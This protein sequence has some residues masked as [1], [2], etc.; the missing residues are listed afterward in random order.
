MADWICS[1]RFWLR[2]DCVICLS[3]PQDFTKQ[4]AEKLEDWVKTLPTVENQTPPPQECAEIG[5]PLPNP[6]QVTKP[7]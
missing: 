3:I 7:A 4:D 2:P 6:A 5:I 1:H